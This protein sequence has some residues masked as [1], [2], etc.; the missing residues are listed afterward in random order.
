MKKTT[1]FLLAI[2]F[3]LTAFFSA[4]AQSAETIWLSATN[5]AYKTGE[6]VIVTVNAI[7]G[8][9]V[10]GLTFQVRY[11]PA[12]L[13]PISA[14]SPIPG[15]NGMPLPQSSGL[16]D[17]TFASTTPQTAN[18]PLAEV[19]FIT[20][21]EC[22][23]SLTLESAAL[24]IRDQKGFAAQL[25]GV[26]V[27]ERNVTLAVS[28]EKGTSDLPAPV[29]GGTPLALSPAESSSG[30]FPSW[31]VILFSLLAGVI[32]VLVAVNLLRKP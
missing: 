19:R 28:P 5:L 20:L 9:P 23:T 27:G 14:T 25:A 18:G 13:Q 1:A 29:A 32:G 22:Q 8:T 26:A 16:V 3:A 6:T 21:A 2:I 30:Q 7:S 24:A 15:M 12:C 4:S 10:Q 17:A 31:L 11:D